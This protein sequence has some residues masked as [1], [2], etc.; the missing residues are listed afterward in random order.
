MQIDKARKTKVSHASREGLDSLPRRKKIHDGKQGKWRTL[1]CTFFKKYKHHW[2]TFH[3]SG[4]QLYIRCKHSS[5]KGTMW[6]KNSMYWFCFTSWTCT[7]TSPDFLFSIFAATTSFKLT[8]GKRGKVQ[9]GVMERSYKIRIGCGNKREL[10][11]RHFLCAKHYSI[12]TIMENARQDWIKIQ[13]V[14]LSFLTC[15]KHSPLLI[16]TSSWLKTKSE[17]ILNQP[18]SRF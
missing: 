17:Q 7:N 12:L 18:S 14:S 16:T 8:R 2:S 1:N 4:P 3:G 6:M 10:K 5:Q 13:S 15:S 11:E 9:P